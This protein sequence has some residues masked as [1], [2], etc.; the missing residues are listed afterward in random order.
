MADAGP[1]PEPMP[2]IGA[3]CYLNA[4]SAALSNWAMAVFI[5]LKFAGTAHIAPTQ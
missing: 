1:G 2:R 5:A 3:F 4:L